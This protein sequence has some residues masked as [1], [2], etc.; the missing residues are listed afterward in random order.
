MVQIEIMTSRP[1]TI[2][3]N[4]FMR[5]L[6]F[7]FV[8]TKIQKQFKNI[9]YNYKI[10]NEKLKNKFFNHLNMLYYVLQNFRK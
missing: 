3:A 9:F 7:F 6:V 1:I 5:K 10:K 8:Y 4:V 2:K